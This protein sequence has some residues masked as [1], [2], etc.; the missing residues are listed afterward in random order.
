MTVL[1]YRARDISGSLVEGEVEGYDYKDLL[2]SLQNQGL[3][4]ISVEE[5]KASQFSLKKL[6]SLFS[7]VKPEELIVFTRQFA[8]LFKAGLSMEIIL[9]TL[10]KQVQNP[11]L[12]EALNS[13]K[14]DVNSGVSIAEAFSKHPKI[15]NT[16]YI[17]M[18]QAGEEAGILEQA[19]EEL[20]I[21]LEKQLEI[22][23]NIKSATLYPK[24]VVFVMFIAAYIILTFIIPKFADFYGKFGADLPFFTM[25]LIKIGSF[26]NTFWWLVF[27]LVGLGIYGFKKYYATYSGRLFIDSL[28][29]KIPVFGTL[30]L[31]TINAQY[32]HLLSSLYKSGLPLPRC[33]EILMEVIQN[34]AFVE[35]LRNIKDGIAMGESIS[36]MMRRG[37][38]FSPIMIET[39]SIGEKTG[40]L[41]EMLDAVSTHYDLEV[42]H[43]TKNL[44]TMI[45][46]MLLCGIFGMV[47]ILLMAV[48]MPMFNMSKAVFNG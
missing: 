37:Q 43:M 33:F 9:S 45:E 8:T 5:S 1:T 47:T 41:D 26:L 12:K 14:V 13:I 4:P 23:A 31:K 19:L 18:L 17:A 6:N 39:T 28:T 48:A 20:T 27:A 3:T 32:G 10:G 22:N 35:D 44:T 40:N 2:T 25:L 46:P 29:F 38:Y 15:F 34:K 24:I 11:K 21:V 16:L 7:K 42:K 36:A 30:A